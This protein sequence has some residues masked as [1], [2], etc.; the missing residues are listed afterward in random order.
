MGIILSLEQIV[1][2]LLNNP[3]FNCISKFIVSLHCT[4]CELCI[5][6]EGTEPERRKR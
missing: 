3:R 4:V 1:T 2:N 6:I 5:N